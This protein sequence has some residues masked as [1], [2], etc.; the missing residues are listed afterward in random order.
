MSTSIDAVL[1]GIVLNAGA[2]FELGSVEFDLFGSGRYMW[3]TKHFYDWKLNGAII[4]PGSTAGRFLINWLSL[5]CGAKVTC[6]LGP[7]LGVRAELEGYPLT[8]NNVDYINPSGA[9]KTSVTGLSYMYEGALVVRPVPLLEINAGYRFE[10]VYFNEN[11][12]SGDFD[13]LIKQS[14]L[15]AGVKMA[16]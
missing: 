15:F 9:G 7:I 8:S 14:G 6:M 11:K 16:F 13:L 3:A 4:A 1:G 12:I 2:N 10:S 5:G